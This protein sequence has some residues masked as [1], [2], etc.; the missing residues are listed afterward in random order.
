MSNSDQYNNVYSR[1]N[2]SKIMIITASQTD[3]QEESILSSQSF[4][5][6]FSTLFDCNSSNQM[7]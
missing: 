7:R 3:V 1:R 4:L 6:L 5:G 2:G